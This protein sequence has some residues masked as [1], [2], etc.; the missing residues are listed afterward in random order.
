[1]SETQWTQNFNYKYTG[2]YELKQGETK[3]VTIARTCTEEVMD[4]SGKKQMCF[5][6]YFEGQSKPMVLNKTNCKTIEKLYSP[7]IEKW[8]GKQICL[9]SK[10]VKAFGDVVDALRVKNIVPRTSKVDITIPQQLLEACISLDDLKSTYLS[11]SKDEQAA[12]V[13]IKDAVKARLSGSK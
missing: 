3:V 8:I 4:T 11:L 7:I 5:V 10:Q 2:A 12:T 13:S 1:M 6:A 9:E